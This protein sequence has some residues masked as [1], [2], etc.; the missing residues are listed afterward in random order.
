MTALSALTAAAGA[1][2]LSYALLTSY[3]ETGPNCPG[4]EPSWIGYCEKEATK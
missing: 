4:M 2:V 1:V 3:V